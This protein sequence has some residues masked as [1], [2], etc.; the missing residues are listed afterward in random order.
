V[1]LR[2]DAKTDP[3]ATHPAA[4][5]PKPGLI[6]GE[7]LWLQPDRFKV[8][9]LI[10]NDVL[11]QIDDLSLSGWG[12]AGMDG[13]VIYALHSY[14]IP[15]QTYRLKIRRQGKEI[16]LPMNPVEVLPLKLELSVSVA[17]VSTGR[18]FPI[19]LTFT[20]PTD[21]S[22]FFT[23]MSCSW[24]EKLRL[25]GTGASLPSWGCDK[26][27]PHEVTLAPGQK[28]ERKLSLLAASVPGK[29]R[30]HLTWS[31]LEGREYSSNDVTIE[32]N[33]TNHK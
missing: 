12:N 17:P 29:H 25:D 16:D 14:L 18:D 13:A 30:F 10:A 8:S 33:S 28:V 32:I 31:P 11:M 22:F 5:A 2:C 6:Y 3:K 20:N 9:G 23:E 19:T 4:Q 21:R 26:N 7:G 1:T 27:A 15:E 24:N